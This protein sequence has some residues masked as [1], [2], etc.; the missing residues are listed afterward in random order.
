M[1]RDHTL[2]YMSVNIEING[3]EAGLRTTRTS[4][5]LTIAAFTRLLSIQMRCGTHV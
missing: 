1:R 4:Y 2:S 5:M 3:Y